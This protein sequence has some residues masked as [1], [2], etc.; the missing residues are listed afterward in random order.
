VN[1]GHLLSAPQVHVL[2]VT[3]QALPSICVPVIRPCRSEYLL[4]IDI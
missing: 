3:F 1:K 4:F 2:P